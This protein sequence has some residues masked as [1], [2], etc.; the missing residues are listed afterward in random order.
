MTSAE[1][2]AH[3]PGMSEC[4]EPTF[5]PSER[6]DR[7]LTRAV[8]YHRGQRRKG[9]G[10][11]YVGHLLAVA[12]YVLEDGG[13]EDEAIAA[14]LHDALE[15]QYRDDLPSEL[16]EEFGPE[17]LAIVEG[18]SQEKLPGEKLTWRE[19]KQRYIDNLEAASPQVCRVSLADKLANVR[20]MLRDH[21]EVGE[22]LW[23]RF[24]AG[25]EN[26]VWFYESLA[27][28]YS[29]LRPGAMAAEFAHEVERLRKLVRS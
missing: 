21:R 17:V 3:D 4:A 26:I 12:G 8:E 29:S 16:R 27:E 6:F 24:N 19:R 22:R 23:T 5:V 7:A 13:S 2:S 18:C 15:D 25:P 10:T 20:S 28:R 14:L 1:R 11:P 9:S